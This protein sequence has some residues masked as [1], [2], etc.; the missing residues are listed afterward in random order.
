MNYIISNLINLLNRINKFDSVKLFRENLLKNFYPQNCST[1]KLFYTA[2]YSNKFLKNIFSSS[3]PK[4]IIGTL[5][6]LKFM[7]SFIFAFA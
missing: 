1:N 2:L 6:G 3:L 7:L 4:F 5:T